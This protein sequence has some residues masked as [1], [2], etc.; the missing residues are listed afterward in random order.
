M[1]YESCCRKEKWT[2]R[3]SLVQEFWARP[4]GSSRPST[5]CRALVAG[6]EG[7]PSPVLCIAAAASRSAW[8]SRGQSI[9]PGG[10][11][12]NA[13]LDRRTRHNV[14]FSNIGLT[15]LYQFSAC[16]M[17]CWVSHLSAEQ[18]MWGTQLHLR[19]SSSVQRNASMRWAGCLR[20]LHADYTAADKPFEQLHATECCLCPMR[21]HVHHMSSLYELRS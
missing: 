6:S 2:V 21:M 1:G 16:A 3:E 18:N 20:T 8:A 12:H 17:T 11:E 14:N 10:S 19:M 5:C 13:C 4:P 9:M 7:Y 15:S